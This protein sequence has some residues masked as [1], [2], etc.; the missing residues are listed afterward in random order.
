MSFPSTT[1]ASILPFLLLLLQGP[2]ATG[3]RRPADT[4]P[5]L[6]HIASPLTIDST[7]QVRKPRPPH[8]PV[9]PPV[10]FL[11][12]DSTTALQSE[13]GGGWGAG[14]LS[15]VNTCTTSTDYAVDGATTISFVADGYWAEVLNAVGN[16]TTEGDFE[17]F[18]TIQVLPPPPFS[19]FFSSPSFF[20][21]FECV[22]CF[23]RF[24][25]S[26]WITLVEQVKMSFSFFNLSSGWNPPCAHSSTG[27]GA[28]KI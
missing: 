25:F 4:A 20:P 9:K 17:P 23:P 22:S 2:L 1:A 13:N 27:T 14:F 7:R 11:A 10:W 26:A 15:F 21:L 3:A 12:G 16:A 24:E 28:D 19:V 8:H 18:V 5:T 6:R